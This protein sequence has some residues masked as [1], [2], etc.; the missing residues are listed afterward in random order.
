MVKLCKLWIILKISSF[1]KMEN[2]NLFGLKTV[3]HGK[4]M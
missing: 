4:I 1:K 2:E 3:N